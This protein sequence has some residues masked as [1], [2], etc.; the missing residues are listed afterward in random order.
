MGQILIKPMALSFEGRRSQGRAAG[1]AAKIGRL[2]SGVDWELVV[3]ILP[4]VLAGLITMKGLGAGESDYFFNRQAIWVAAGFALFFFAS[5]VDWRFLRNGWTLVALYLAGLGV[6]AA[7][8]VFSEAVRGAQSWLSL[9]IFSLEPAEP[10]KLVLV[11]ILAKYFSRRHVE[12]RHTRHIFVSGLY[13][14]L[15]TLLIFLQPDLGSAAIFFFIW[16]GVILVSGVSKRH[17]AL[18][19]TV[20]VCAALIGWFYVLAPYQKARLSSFIDPWRDPEGVGYNALQSVTAVGSGGFWGRGIGFG[21]QSRLEFLPEHETDFIFAAFAEE[22]GFLGVSV[23]L[24]FFGVVFWRIMKAAWAGHSNFEKLFGIGLVLIVL[25]H[26]V[27]NIGMNVGM[28]PI[29]GITL[30]FLSYGGSHIITLFFGLGMLLGMKQYGYESG[31]NQRE[32]D[33]TL[34]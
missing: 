5:T 25:A 33:L 20:I 21:T 26:F 15:P 16:L 10:M 22:W 13:A 11:L 1:S 24:F 19:G 7:L 4:L 32:S 23:L 28:L 34:I 17:I 30:P 12:I 29:T 8:L 18:V 9:G 2:S 14:G 6:L 27:I 3:A 31:G